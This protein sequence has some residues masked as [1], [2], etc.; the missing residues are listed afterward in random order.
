MK[1]HYK[2]RGCKCSSKNCTCDKTWSVVI[3]IGKNLQTG[4][5]KQKTLSGFKTKQDAEKA[6]TALLNEINRGTYFEESNILFKEFID[7]WLLQYTNKVNPKIST[8]R[9]RKY[10]IYKL[11]PYFIYAS[12]K[13]ITPDLYQDAINDLTQK[14]YSQST[15]QGIHSTAKMLFSFATSK[16]YIKMNPTLNAYVQREE[17]KIVEMDE[18]QLPMYFE[19]EELAKFL[20]TVKEKGLYLDVL[21]FF[22]LSYTGLR[23]GELVALKWRNIDFVNNTISV[24]KTYYNP[25]NNTKEYTLLPPKTK[26]SRRT[27][28]VDEFLMSLFKSHYQE[29]QQLIKVLGDNYYDEQFV[30]T[31]MNTHFGYPVLIKQIENRMHR[32][33]K[34][35]GLNP[36]LTPHS[37]RHTHTSL[38][39]EAGVDLDQIMERLGHQ[40]DATTRNIYLH[41]TSARKSTAANKFSELMSGIS[42]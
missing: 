31:N 1:G 21:I 25:N 14:G 3:D 8:I 34:L 6:V 11:L 12:V 36:S 35:S 37:L 10:Y 17:Q 30:F 13:D 18:E 33:L 27:I 42:A 20:Q 4:K 26:K 29:Q 39:A 38:L 15:L 2:K 28:I 9:L 7:I 40:D 23:I 19:K 24:T 5:R 16:N 22:T 32:L 41:I